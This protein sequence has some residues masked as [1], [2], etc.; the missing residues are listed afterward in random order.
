MPLEPIKPKDVTVPEHDVSDAAIA[1]INKQIRETIN[2]TGVATISD[3]EIPGTGRL[4]SGQVMTLFNKYGWDVSYQPGGE[5]YDGRFPGSYTF[6]I[7]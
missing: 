2:S 7:S 4:P 1:Y 5:G 3:N 6:R